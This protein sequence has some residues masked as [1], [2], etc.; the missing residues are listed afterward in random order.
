MRPLTLLNTRAEHQLASLTKKIEAAGARSLEVPLIRIEAVTPPAVPTLRKEDWL[1]FTSVNSVHFWEALVPDKQVHTACVGEKTAAAARAKGYTV[2]LI[3][4][5][6]DAESLAEALIQRTDEETR[7][8][9]PRSA[10]SRMVLKEQLTAAGRHFADPVVYDTVP[11]EAS[12]E[13]LKKAVHEVDGVLFL[14]P[15]AVHAFFHFC[16]THEIPPLFYGCIGGVTEEVCRSYT[17]RR[18]IVPDTYTIEAL[19][20]KI[21]KE[22][23]KK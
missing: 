9:Y 20:T 1:V 12:Q 4:S 5:Q 8:V 17:D 22:K 19:L 7:I 2:S 10:K 16:G 15:S 3:P 18:I 13:N 11:N 6:Y 23:V 14:S 21:M